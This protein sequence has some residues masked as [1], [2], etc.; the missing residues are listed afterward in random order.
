MA[1]SSP[2]SMSKDQ[3]GSLP[4]APWIPVPCPGYSTGISVYTAFRSIPWFLRTN[5]A[6]T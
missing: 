6:M 5:H 4:A 1:P 3:G 2:I